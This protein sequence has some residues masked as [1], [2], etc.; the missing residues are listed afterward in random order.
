MSNL[1]VSAQFDNPAQAS[2]FDLMCL[3]YDV[4]KQFGVY[5]SGAADAI[6]KLTEDFFEEMHNEWELDQSGNPSEDMA[7][8]IG[9]DHPPLRVA[10]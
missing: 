3:V 9:Q 8:F 6:R 10:S 5:D 1:V 7:D 4:L 2:E